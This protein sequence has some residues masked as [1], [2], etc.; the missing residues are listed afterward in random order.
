MILVVVGKGVQFDPLISGVSLW[1]EVFNCN[2]YTELVFGTGL[3]A[4]GDD[5]F[6]VIRA[7]QSS[8]EQGMGSF[9]DNLEKKYSSASGHSKNT[10][11]TT[12]SS[13]AA[14]SSSTGGTGNTTR[15]GKSRRKK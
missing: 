3:S 15:K 11:D 6:A 9:F 7:R 1:F 10:S 14:N 4:D 2:L 13:T 12:S 8:R 5:L